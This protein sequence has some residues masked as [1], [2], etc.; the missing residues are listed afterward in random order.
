MIKIGTF[1][2]ELCV[3]GQYQKSMREIFRNKELLLV[4]L[5]QKY[6]IPLPESFGAFPQ[7]HSH[8]IDFSADHTYQLVLRKMLLKMK[9]S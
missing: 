5:R 3:I 4:L 2:A 7:I 6:T 1:V 8:I 9:T